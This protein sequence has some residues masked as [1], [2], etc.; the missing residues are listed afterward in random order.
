[1]SDRTLWTWTRQGT[2][3]HVRRGK[4]I[5]YPTAALARWLDGELHHCGAYAGLPKAQNQAWLLHVMDR[6]RS[7]H[8][9]AVEP[10]PGRLARRPRIQSLVKNREKK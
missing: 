1:M 9:P 3:P 2:I 4:T 7:P 6:D 5:L 10:S 8:R